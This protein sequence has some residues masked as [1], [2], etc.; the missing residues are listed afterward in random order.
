VYTAAFNQTEQGKQ[1]GGKGT[2]LG[3]ALV[4]QIVKR[5]GGRLGVSSRVGKGSTFW[6][7]LRTSYTFRLLLD[8]LMQYMLLALGIGLETIVPRT[9]APVPLD[10]EKPPSTHLS[11]DV[12]NN[13]SGEVRRSPHLVIDVEPPRAS[14]GQGNRRASASGALSPTGSQHSSAMHSLM[15]QGGLVEIGPNAH[16]SPSVITRTI[17]DALAFATSPEEEVD[18]PV[19]AIAMPSPMSLE[20]PAL[21]SPVS[22]HDMPPCTSQN[23][24]VVVTFAT[25]R[26]PSPVLANPPDIAVPLL[27]PQPSRSLGGSEEPLTAVPTGLPVLVVDDDALTRTLMTRMLS[28][29]GCKVSTAENGSA[30]LDMVLGDCSGRFAVVFLDNQMPVMSGLSMVAKLREAG[31]SDFVVGVTGNA[32]LTDQEEYLEAGVDKCVPFPAIPLLM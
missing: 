26:Q 21:P 4:R 16:A 9:P 15:E 29:L 24:E 25:P 17:G 6:V 5:S 19:D 18:D 14:T 22:L 13:T 3:L 12:L 7:E 20:L 31:R 32:L 30:A 23:P 28:R 11:V 8:A 10:D 27:R 2:G 1:Q